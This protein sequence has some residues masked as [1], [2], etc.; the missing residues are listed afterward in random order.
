MKVAGGDL[1]E[2]GAFFSV[3]D[4]EFDDGVVTVEPVDVDGVTVEVGQEG[5][6]T[7]SG[8]S[9]SWAGS[10]SRVRRTISRRVTWRRPWPVV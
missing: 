4:G 1:F 6:V 9:R 3:A 10:L 5:V 7:P 2:S 8:H